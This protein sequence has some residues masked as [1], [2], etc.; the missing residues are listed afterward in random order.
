MVL[1]LMLVAWGPA[2]GAAQTDDAKAQATQYFALGSQ[3]YGAKRFQEA[4]LEFR[5]SFEAYGSPNTRFAIARCLRELGRYPEAVTE[6]ELTIHEAADRAAS[7]STYRATA[8][9]ARAELS[10]VL[11][12]V[13]RVK[14]EVFPAEAKASVRIN[15]QAV[16]SEAL[17]NPYPVAPGTVVIEV[18]AS[19]YVAVHKELEMAA[20]LEMVTRV[21]LSSIADAARPPASR[22]K[23]DGGVA[24]LG[25]LPR[26]ESDSLVPILGW[27]GVGAGVVA[28][29]LFAAFYFLSDG[30]HDDL[31][32][33]CV[34]VPCTAAKRNDLESTGRTYETVTNVA[35]FVGV[36]A[37]VTGGAL[38]L[39][40]AMD[41]P[42]RDRAGR[43][44]PTLSLSN[45]GATVGLRTEF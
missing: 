45:T 15:G 10:G 41:A 32:K 44:T 21:A 20:G 31:V 13:G 11:A 36:G 6:Y 3:H 26:E 43:A 22:P 27:I 24:E 17:A 12:R 37:L 4:L 39:W 40:D 19:G 34:D 42:P 25:P 5:R 16:S 2:P 9:A 7:D 8:D 14:V 38:L 33:S 1:V 18:S 28:G 30:Q 29:G 23:E 35:L